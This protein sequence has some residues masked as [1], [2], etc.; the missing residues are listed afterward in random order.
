M[1][2]QSILQY[3]NKALAQ[4]NKDLH[5]RVAQLQQDLQQKT[6]EA[7]HAEQA[8]T[9]SIGRFASTLVKVNLL[10]LTRYRL[11]S[12]C[13]WWHSNSARLYRK[14][15]LSSRFWRRRA[16]AKP[17]QFTSPSGLCLPSLSA[18]PGV[19]PLSLTQLLHTLPGCLSSA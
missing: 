15:K 8:T 11:T 6:S 17:N 3:Q 12:L 1:Q 9:H 5:Q 10:A 4:A 14:S 2:S 19:G 16:L 7:T 18:S 13:G